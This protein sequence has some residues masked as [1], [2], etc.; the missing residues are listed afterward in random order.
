MLQNYCLF[1]PDENYFLEVKTL[2]TNVDKK[3]TV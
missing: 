1:Q 3:V 2:F